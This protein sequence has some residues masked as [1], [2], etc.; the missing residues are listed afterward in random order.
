MNEIALESPA[1]GAAPSG[2]G[3]ELGPL[4]VP[5]LPPSVQKLLSAPTALKTMAAKGI[6]PLR[7]ADLLTVVYQLAFDPEEGVRAASQAAPTGIPDKILA[8]ALAE[9][10]PAPVLQFFAARL[11]PERTAV[12]EPILYNQATS[13][14]TFILLASRLRERELE[15]IFQNEA[16]ILRCPAILESLYFNRQAR[17]S[18]L[19]RAIELCARNGLRLEGIPCFDD[20]AKSIAQDVGATDPAVADAGFTALL[21]TAETAL[22]VA[23]DDGAEKG[24]NGEQP[25]GATDL[26]GAESGQAQAQAAGAQGG[27]QSGEQGAQKRE[28]PIIDFTRLKLYEKIRLATLGNAYCRKNLLRDPNRMVAMA[29]IRSPRITDSEIVNAAGNR[30]VCEDV[31]RYIANQRDLTK[32]YQV[33]LNLVQNPK[34]PVALS[35]KFLPFLQAEDL[36]HIARSKNVPSAL[37]VG[38]RRLIQNRAKKE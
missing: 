31:I 14:Q 24:E 26:G 36:K 28:S 2:L 5:T 33:K 6:A 23:L 4:P 27:D 19:N 15:I 1:A 17:M 10:L 8:P 9:A 7:P 16:R 18:S 12:L 29:A 30:S 3:L 22:P 25:G 38:A 37:T 21:A 34:C 20:V 13:D 32:T 35:L 11:A